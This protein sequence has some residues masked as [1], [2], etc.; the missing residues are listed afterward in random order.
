MSMCKKVWDALF[1]LVV[2]T[3]FTYQVHSQP[4]ENRT[5]IIQVSHILHIIANTCRP[6]VYGHVKLNTS[7]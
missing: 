4:W 3:L 7:T 6:E 1:F 5:F 2:L